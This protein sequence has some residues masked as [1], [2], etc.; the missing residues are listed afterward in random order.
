MKGPKQPDAAGA[1]REHL[2]GGLDA[3]FRL[4]AVV[5][6]VIR[7][8]RLLERGDTIVVGVSGGPDSVALLH[9]LHKL[10]TAWDW[11]L[12]VAHVNHRFR[13]E[14]SDR[15][16]DFV[17]SFAKKLGLTCEVGNIDVPAYIEETSLNS[18]V[19]A[20]KKRYQFLYETARRYGAS[21]IAL[22]HHAD[23]QAETILMRILRGTG[24][25]GLT[26]I[27]QRRFE[28]KV[29][30]V[31]PLL[32]IYKKEVSNYCRFEE[33]AY[34]RDSSNESRKYNRNRIRLDAMP[35]L[36]QFNGQ[37]PESL[38]RLGEIM[39]EENAYMEKEAEGAFASIAALESGAVTMQRADFVQL[40]VALQRRVIKLILN[41]LTFQ[42]EN[43]DYVRL[44]AIR[45]GIVQEQP[46]NFTMPI[47]GA[48]HLI[49]EYDCI[50]FRSKMSDSADA[51]FLYP[52]DLSQSY[53]LIPQ[54]DAAL[55]F[56]TLSG[57]LITEEAD[58]AAKADEE[59]VWF[60]LD[61]LRLPLYVR[62]RQ[63]GD[64]LEPFGLNGTKKVKDILMD[65]KIPPSRRARLPL[66]VDAEGTVLWIPG[67]R[68]SRHA[69]IRPG[70]I[71]SLYLRIEA[72]DGAA[73]GP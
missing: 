6:R 47:D 40:H 19:A 37:L 53:L 14:E 26:G 28:K 54:A 60:D 36:Q 1:D 41:Y 12:I 5:E 30:L 63:V 61:A 24:P 3:G 21:R 13:G 68:R 59:G 15:E 43:V 69:L 23:D 22:A 10:S 58:A 33:L 38:N 34:C 67:I 18:Q 44:E 7:E 49:R 11:K 29:E 2:T 31:R 50:C 66:L 27:P 55:T 48:F 56:K 9:L 57:E 51:A 25:A 42:A 62:S 32:R 16:A 8:E 39:T 4:R 65:A 52:L 73:E 20:R 64:R 71:R 70:T 35:F 46:A 72:G 17:A 45:T